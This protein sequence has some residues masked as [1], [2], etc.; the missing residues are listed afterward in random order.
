MKTTFRSR[1]I[2]NVCFM[3]CAGLFL[4]A[5]GAGPAPAQVTSN[6]MAT[7]APADPSLIFPS[8]DRLPGK[9]PPH[10][11]PGLANSVAGE[12]RA[13]QSVGNQ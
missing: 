1:R 10:V 3:V 2:V 8:L 4:A 13:L 11:W 5:A 7:S 12:S 6:S 9:V